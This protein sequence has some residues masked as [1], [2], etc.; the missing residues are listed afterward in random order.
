MA[1]NEQISDIIMFRGLGFSQQEVADTVGLSRQA[2]A[3]QLQRLKKETLLNGA[4]VTFTRKTGLSEADSNE[5]KEAR[6]MVE[7]LREDRDRQLESDPSIVRQ[8]IQS[9]LSEGKWV[10]L[11]VIH[12]TLAKTFLNFE[13]H[14]ADW[15]KG[16]P[17]KLREK[18]GWSDSLAEEV[19]GLMGEDL[20][21]QG[22]GKSI[23]TKTRLAK[24]LVNVS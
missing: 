20:E 17:T 9:T 4:I 16:W 6:E 11:P 21:F 10:A 2:V 5:I 14:P 18:L 3:Y 8:T 19:Q 12:F 7:I 23:V 1:T 22:L 24:A 13:G 15:E